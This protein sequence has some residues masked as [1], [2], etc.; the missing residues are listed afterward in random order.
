MPVDNH[1]L[2]KQTLR[3][4]TMAVVKAIDYLVQATYFVKAR[5]RKGAIEFSKTEYRDSPSEAMRLAKLWQHD[6]IEL[7]FSRMIHYSERDGGYSNEPPIYEEIGFEDLERMVT[8]GEKLP[9]KT[10]DIPITK[11][12]LDVAVAFEKSSVHY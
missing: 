10:Y 2:Y 7:N 8:E 9:R 4:L 11:I 5:L 1:N 3:I 12:E 6:E